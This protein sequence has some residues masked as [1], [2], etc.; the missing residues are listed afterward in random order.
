VKIAIISSPYVAVPPPG[1]GGTERVIHYLIK[2]L[3]ELGH[4]PILLGTGDSKV[5]CE[6]IPIVE[7][8]VT[9]PKNPAD[10]PQFNKFLR[11]S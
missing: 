9:F 5:K 6:L 11:S 1:Y 3:L 7:K 2:G 10:L 4:E 8:A